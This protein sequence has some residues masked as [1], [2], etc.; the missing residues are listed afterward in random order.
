MAANHGDRDTLPGAER[1]VIVKYVRAGFHRVRNSFRTGRLERALADELEAHLQ[2]HIDDNVR[3]G[4]SPD[5]ARRHALLSLG[6]VESVKEHYRDRRGIPMLEVILKDLRFGLR[7]L[8]KQPAF[9]FG[10]VAALTIGVAA[11]VLV[12]SIANA[13]VI[14]P[15]P[16]SDP[17]AVVRAYVDGYSNTPYADYAAYRD[18]NHT[19]SG[20]AAFPNVPLLLRPTPVSQALSATPPPR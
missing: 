20:L 3:A 12:F 14:R 10:A 5:D 19:L 2:L 15:L 7:L 1:A 9:T 17:G 11:N 6:G 18:R 8:R 4:M 16:I 13:L